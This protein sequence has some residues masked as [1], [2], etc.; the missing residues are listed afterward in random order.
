M[1][2]EPDLIFE[3]AV[4]GRVDFQEALQ[5]DEGGVIR[6]AGV[7]ADLLV[8]QEFAL[9]VFEHPAPVLRIFEVPRF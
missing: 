4:R 8:G 2:H 1:L 9:A 3:P 7:Q 6:I 5:V